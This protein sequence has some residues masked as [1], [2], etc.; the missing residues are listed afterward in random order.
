VNGSGV[1]S[2][3]TPDR[4]VRQCTISHLSTFI[5]FCSVLYIYSLLSTFYFYSLHCLLSTLSTLSS[6]RHD[7][8]WSYEEKCRKEQEATGRHWD[9]NICSPY[10]NAVAC[11][12]AGA[13]GAADGLSTTFTPAVAGDQ[14]ADPPIPDTHAEC[15]VKLAG[16]LPCDCEGK[17]HTCIL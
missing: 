10:Q 1:Y 4:G 16:A 11:A 13:Y 5:L 9:H 8:L 7:L 14:N 3:R 6:H 17:N 15:E 12:A 2:R